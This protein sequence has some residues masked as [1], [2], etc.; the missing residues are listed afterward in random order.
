MKRSALNLVRGLS[1]IAIW[2]IAGAA[3]AQV[4]A[5]GANITAGTTVGERA[6]Y[7]ARL[8]SLLQ[9]L[10]YNVQVTNAGVDGDTTAGMLARLD[11]AVP[12]GT[13]VVILAAGEGIGNDQQT[14]ETRSQAN[15]DIDS[16][17]SRLQ[18]RQIAVI[19][20]AGAFA[21]ETS[22][23]L[24]EHLQPDGVHLTAQGQGLAAARL[25]P[26]VIDALRTSG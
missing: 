10:G 5:L 24:S 14:G 3:H 22:A 26:E 16:M 19:P 2:A 25:L 18:A 6:A 9:S 13:K 1:A 23:G 8:E 21:N 15:V 20:A 4:V 12:D 17:V 7:P 11:N